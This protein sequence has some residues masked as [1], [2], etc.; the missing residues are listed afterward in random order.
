MEG[1]E[2]VIHPHRSNVHP[3][4]AI[5]AVTSDKATSESRSCGGGEL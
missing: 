4:V 1:V 2:S 3:R 5:Y